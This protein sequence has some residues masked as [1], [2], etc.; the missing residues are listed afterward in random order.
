[1]NIKRIT[2][3]LACLALLAGCAATGPAFTSLVAPSDNEAAVYVIGPTIPPT[4][5]PIRAYLSTTNKKTR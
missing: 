4:E 1:M 2:L 5:T 3:G